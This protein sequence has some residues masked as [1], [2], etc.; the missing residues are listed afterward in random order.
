M[1]VGQILF[2]IYPDADDEGK[3]IVEQWHVRSIRGGKITAIWFS[4]TT[5]GKRSKKHGDFGWLDPIAR[6]ARK[7]WKVDGPLPWG[8]F[9][10]KKQ[11][12]RFE[13]KIA[14][15]SDFDDP[16]NLERWVAALKRMRV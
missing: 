6:Y 5:W 13:L 7:S 15:A 2:C 1:K 8:L 4:S 9:T 16:A 12:V 3:P 10:T 11:V 14:Q